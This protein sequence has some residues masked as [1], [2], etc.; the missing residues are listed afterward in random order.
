[1][2]ISLD[3]GGGDQAGTR[4][5]IANGYYSFFLHAFLT[6]GAWETAT[7][8]K[9]WERCPF[10]QKIPPL[11]AYIAPES[12]DTAGRTLEFITGVYRTVD[13]D[14]ASLAKWMVDRWGRSK[15]ALVHRLILG[16][17]RVQAKSPAQLNLPLARYIRGADAFVSRSSWE[18]DA[19][20]VYAVA[21]YLDTSRYEHE[22]G[23]FGIHKGSTRL[24]TRGWGSKTKATPA[25]HSGLWV[26]NPATG[27]YFQGSTYWSGLNN[28]PE[29]THRADHALEVVTRRGTP[30]I[31]VSFK[32]WVSGTSVHSRIPHPSKRS[33]SP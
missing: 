7:G 2:T 31:P 1:M 13:P 6:L 30:A 16:D 25:T 3:D 23:T 33:T 32:A 24:A 5:Q 26:C 22:S 18:D 29:K 15:Y 10:Y 27:E 20:V 17:M 4:L 21:R 19:T 14:M 11:W 28:Y 8:E 12:S 9:M